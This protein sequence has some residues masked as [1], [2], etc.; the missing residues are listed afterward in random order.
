MHQRGR[1]ARR[2]EARVLRRR[3]PIGG[4]PWAQFATCAWGGEADVRATVSAPARL[5]DVPAPWSPSPKPGTIRAPLDGFASDVFV[6]DLWHE[7]VR[8]VADGDARTA[9]GPASGSDRDRASGSEPLSPPRNTADAAAIGVVVEGLVVDDNVLD[10]LPGE[11]RELGIWPVS[12]S[13]TWR[14]GMLVAD[15]LAGRLPRRRVLVR[16]RPDGDLPRQ[17]AGRGRDPR[18]SRAAGDRRPAVARAG[19]LLRRG[20]AGGLHED[21]PRF[22]PGRVDVRRME[23]DSWS[24]RAD[25]CAT[26]AVFACGSG[27]VT[28]ETSPLGQSGIGFALRD[29][30]PTIWLGFPSAR[31]R[32]ATTAPRRRRCRT[33]RRIAGRP[34]SRSSSQSSGATATGAPR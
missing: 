31:S 24:F 17:R 16:Q 20:P 11:E 32:C 3:V 33:C 22:T 28:T 19:A 12:A 2:A 4:A 21:L 29:G 14:A 25:R 8:L 18:L 9:P 26:P 23:S 27:L 30:C 6:L 1:L 5:V 34:A 15:A 10:L 13:S 7:P